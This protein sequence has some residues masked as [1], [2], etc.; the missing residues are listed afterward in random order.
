MQLDN[1]ATIFELIKNGLHESITV[2]FSEIE[3]VILHAFQTNFRL[4]APS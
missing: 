1:I 2:E 4:K 3:F